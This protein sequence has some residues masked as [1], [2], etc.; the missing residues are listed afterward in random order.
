MKIAIVTDAIYP[1]TVGGSEIRNY[2]IAKRLVK[3]GH[4]VHIYG[5]Q[6]W[7]GESEKTLDGIKI[8]GVSK[9]VQLYYAKGRRS[10]GDPLKLSWKLFFKLR[11]EHFDLIETATFVYPN[12]LVTK[13]ISKVHGNSLVFVWH[14]YFGTYLFDYLGKIVGSASYLLEYFSTKLCKNNL[15]VSKNVQNT[16]IEKG[17]KKEKTFVIYNGF[18]KELMNLAPVKK[19][20]FDILFVGRLNYQKN[21]SLLIETGSLLKKTIPHIKIRLI[22]EGPEKKNLTKTIKDFGLSKN[23]K[24]LGRLEKTEVYSYMKSSRLFVLPSL[25]EGFP[26][27]IVEANAAGLPIVTVK[28]KHNNTTEYVKNNVNG[29]VVDPTKEDLTKNILEILKNEKLRL[30]LSEKSMKKA[31][32]YSWEKITKKLEKDYKKIIENKKKS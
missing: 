27:T 26:L 15:C 8:H 22:G 13:L 14:Q 19:E 9:Y 28:S 12:C 5:A 20:T 24:F 7:E 11:K 18:D 25:L 21:L 32:E 4:E 29:R 2:E 6:F 3:K 23:V 1:Y 30:E 17:V 31:N 16:L 10:I